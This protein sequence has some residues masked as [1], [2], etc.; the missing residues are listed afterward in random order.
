VQPLGDVEVTLT[1][2]AVQWCQSVVFGGVERGARAVQPLGDVEVAVTAGGVK[3]LL[4]IFS[5]LRP[6]AC[7]V[8]HGCPRCLQIARPHGCKQ[9]RVRATAC[10]RARCVAGR[11]LST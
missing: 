8:R 6:H 4:T 10:A 1:A 9:P 2:G 5:T 3:W 11:R 7:A